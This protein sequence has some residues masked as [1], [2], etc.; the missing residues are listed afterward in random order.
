MPSYR[1]SN[2]I[3]TIYI[4]MFKNKEL[5]ISLPARDFKFSELLNKTS[6]SI[7]ELYKYEKTIHDLSAP[8]NI[9]LALEYCP[10]EFVERLK[11]AIK[12][13]I[14]PEIDGLNF[15]ASFGFNFYNSFWE[16]DFL[17][18]RSFYDSGIINISGAHPLAAYFGAEWYSRPIEFQTID[19]SNY[20]IYTLENRISDIFSKIATYSKNLHKPNHNPRTITNAEIKEISAL[21]NIPEP[22]PKSGGR[23]ASIASRA[24]FSLAHIRC[25]TTIENNYIDT[26]RSIFGSLPKNDKISPTILYQMA[27]PIITQN[28][29]PYNKYTGEKILR[30]LSDLLYQPDC[31]FASPENYK[32]ISTND[33]LFR[34]YQS[35]LSEIVQRVATSYFVPQL[36]KYPQLDVP[37][38]VNVIYPLLIKGF[39]TL[40]ASMGLAE[41]AITPNPK[42]GLPDV[43]F[44]RPTALLSYAKGLIEE[45]TP[46]ES[47]DAG[48]SIRLSDDS[49]TIIASNQNILKILSPYIERKQSATRAIVSLQSILDGCYNKSDLEHIRNIILSMA[50]LKKLPRNWAE[51]FTTAES[52]FIYLINKSYNYRAFQIVKQEKSVRKIISEIPDLEANV[53][54]AERNIFLVPDYLWYQFIESLQ[55]LGISLKKLY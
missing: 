54:Y 53:V 29:T 24:I 6:I 32:W 36:D 50:N 28:K 2:A 5:S 25:Q 4:P 38:I 51:L 3:L 11:K 14:W 18:F 7:P 12:T 13:M 15:N 19:L 23:T 26:V 34:I 43:A 52:K 35:N 33:L 10:R 9:K 31:D 45:Y 55:N 1:Q 8:E 16:S 46:A 37:D 39:C 44:V 27:L 20:N 48:P 49:Y 40:M 17:A 41:I 22:F 21:T 47:V 42:A 30:D